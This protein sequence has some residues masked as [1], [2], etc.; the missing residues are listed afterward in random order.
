MTSPHAGAIGH[1]EVMIHLEKI[2]G[3]ALEETEVRRTVRNNADPRTH[4]N[5][6]A[7]IPFRL[8]AQ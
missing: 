2:Y 3:D 1:D 4:P 6:F 7:D 8:Q 5:H